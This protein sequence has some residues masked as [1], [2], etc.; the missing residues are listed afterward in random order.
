MELTFKKITQLIYLIDIVLF[1]SLFLRFSRPEVCKK[2]RLGC[3]VGFLCLMGAIAFIIS[4][5]SELFGILLNSY[6]IVVGVALLVGLIPL[7]EETR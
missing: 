3:K 6:K 7:Y 1:V 2:S 4:V 5:C